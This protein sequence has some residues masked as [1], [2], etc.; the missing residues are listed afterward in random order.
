MTQR[1]PLRL[2]GDRLAGQELEDG[3]E[4]LLHHVALLGGIDAHHEGV[5]GQGARADAEHDA[6]ARQVVEQHHAVR[7]HERVVVGQRRDARAEAD[8][9]GALRRG[10]DED[11]G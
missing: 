7:Q 5:G 9:P 4:R 10:G 3:L 1:E 8:V 2:H 6:A 11:L